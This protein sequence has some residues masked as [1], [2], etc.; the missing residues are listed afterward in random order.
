MTSRIGGRM[1]LKV[2]IWCGKQ[3]M[4]GWCGGEKMG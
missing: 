1:D 2:I 3:D 4:E